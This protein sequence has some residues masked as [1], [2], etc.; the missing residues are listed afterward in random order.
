MVQIKYNEKSVPSA[1][2]FNL[3]GKDPEK[4]SLASIVLHHIDPF[5]R[6]HWL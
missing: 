4:T 6:A 2:Y 5:H 1:G 3:T